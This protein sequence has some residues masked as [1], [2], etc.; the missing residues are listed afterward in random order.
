MLYTNTLALLDKLDRPRAFYESYISQCMHATMPNGRLDIYV[1]RTPRSLAELENTVRELYAISR[2]KASVEPHRESIEVTVLI[3]G[4][5]LERKRS[6]KWEVIVAPQHSFGLPRLFRSLMADS[7]VIQTLPVLLIK[8]EDEYVKEGEYNATNEK[9]DEEAGLSF[10]ATSPTRTSHHPLSRKAVDDE[11]EE[12]EQLRLLQEREEHEKVLEEHK[13][14]AN[15]VNAQYSTVAVGGTFDHL[16]AGHKVLLTIAG[17]LARDRLIVGITGP[18]LLKNKQYA[19]VLQP[20]STRKD[21]V[22]SFMKYVYPSLELEIEMI[23][24][25]YGP[26]ATIEDIQALVVSTETRDG[27]KS[28]NAFRENKG[29]NKLE[30][31]EIQLVGGNESE[32]EK[33]SSTFLRKLEISKKASL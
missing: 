2:E 6:Q 16:H 11:F 23:N 29:W 20:F 13:F 12:E 32:P 27:G 1:M 15:I 33:L 24:D 10:T 18:E 4:L 5:D 22:V 21:L 8:G 19:E 3:D 26:T 7:T 14:R 9:N 31:I 28:I 30:I 17:F 25:I